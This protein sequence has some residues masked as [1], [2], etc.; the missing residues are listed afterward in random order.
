MMGRQ[1]FFRVEDT[2]HAPNL[3]AAIVGDSARARKGTATDRVLRM[4]DRIDASFTL[5]N[6]VGGMSSG[7]GLINALRDPRSEAVEV[8]ERGAPPRMEVQVVD[9]GVSDKRLL[10]CES[11]FAQALQAA[12]REGSILSPILRDCWDG[13]TLRVLSRSNKDRASDPH[14]SIIANITIE[15]LQRLL[16]SNDK[17][18]GFANRFL[19]CCAKRS[20]LL[21][22][23]GPRID[24]AALGELARRMRAA[25][26]FAHS[27]GEIGWAREAY[28]AWEKLYERL[29]APVGGLFG[30]LTAR[31][32]A[33]C[34]RLALLYALLDCSHEI[35]IEH[36]RAAVE[37]WSYAEDSVRHIYGDATGDEL[38]DSILKLFAGDTAGLSM[39][40]ISS[41]FGRNR[42]SKDLRRALGVLEGRGL[43]TQT[44]LET[45]G[46]PVTIWA[47][48]TKLTKRTN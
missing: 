27:A 46:A 19:W 10:I 30:T 16:T 43:V 44:R 17:G 35:R 34:R 48:V 32:D 1:R 37:V 39:T 7:E 29:S 22:H 9:Q 23:G 21:P 6:R 14:V 47:A 20:K 5:S 3:F 4:L 38:A 25:V 2:I 26:D 33:Q 12:S 45:K 41:S 28:T 36:L 40:E 31:A 8:K 13:K 24:E 15:E 11:E 42:S 18:N